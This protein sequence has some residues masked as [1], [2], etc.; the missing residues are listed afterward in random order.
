MR[1]RDAQKAAAL[2]AAL[3][4]HGVNT[5]SLPGV[6][7]AAE[8][9]VLVEQL[10]DSIRRVE[11]ARRLPTLTNI[12]A[13]RTDPNSADF[14]PLKAAVFH[15]RAGNLD[16]AFW[17]V[18]LFV[19]FGKH[20]GLDWNYVRAV[21]GR[22]GGG[23]RWDWGAVS[24]APRS[25]RTWL[26]ANK[27]AIVATGGGFGNHRKYISLDAWSNGGTGA[28]FETYVDWIGPAHD[29]LAFMNAARNAAGGDPKVTFAALYRSMSPIA[30]FGRT[31]RF[32][33]LAM[34][35]KLRLAAIE[36]DRP[37]LPGATGPLAG[38]RLLYGAP[39]TQAHFLDGWL[40]ELDSDLSV[41]MQVIEDALCN[42]QKS[43]AAYAR[44]RG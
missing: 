11:Y 42:W 30:S 43:P 7:S 6:Q 14:D 26:D 2:D 35:G 36:P 41:G 4:S 38:A 37:Y 34:L 15:G 31:G 21:Y 27:A 23:G 40:V 19:H 28:A 10:L 12:A 16:E 22:L 8:R 24:A 5:R 13:S 29:H 1:P 25:F 32:D 44:F 18:F 3:Q 20:R 17:L 9:G 33:Y 39:F